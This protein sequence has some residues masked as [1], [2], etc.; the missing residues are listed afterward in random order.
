[1]LETLLLNDDNVDDTNLNKAA[2][3]IEIG[4]AEVKAWRKQLNL[5][6]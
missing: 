5:G 1:M 3:W 6:G 2:F 4:F